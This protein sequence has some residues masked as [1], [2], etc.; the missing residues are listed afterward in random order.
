MKRKF[1][2]TIGT[3]LLALLFVF[4]LQAVQAAVS[5][6]H[7]KIS[8]EL[9]EKV[10]KLQPGEKL[11]VYVWAYEP[12]LSGI[13]QK[14]GEILGE[15]SEYPGTDEDYLLAAD[16][17]RIKL[18]SEYFAAFNKE[19]L[20]ELGLKEKDLVIQRTDAP[21][22]IV[23]LTNEQIY[24]FSEM[25]K[26]RGLFL[27]DASAPSPEEIVYTYTSVHALQIL[28]A[29]VGLRMGSINWEYDVDRDG[30]ITVLDALLALQSSVGLITVSWPDDAVFPE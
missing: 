15:Q 21:L 5:A 14:L 9:L 17:L 30:Q 1:A 29:V 18:Y 7:E 12:D 22:I 20:E 6:P 28:Q 10:Q 3:V 8:P 2:T 13:N 19:F 27:Y 25:D 24:R 16:A 11:P 4:P 26:V 23:W